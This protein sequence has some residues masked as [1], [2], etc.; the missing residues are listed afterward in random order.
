[1][2]DFYELYN[3]DALAVAQ[4]TSLKVVDRKSKTRL[5]KVVLN[6]YLIVKTFL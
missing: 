2:G 5:Q 6:I 1:M 4:Y 3:E